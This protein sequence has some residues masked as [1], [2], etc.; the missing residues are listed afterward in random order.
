MDFNPD[1]LEGKSK[2]EIINEELIDHILTSEEEIEDQQHRSGSQTDLNLYLLDNKGFQIGELEEQINRVFE[3]SHI[4]GHAENFFEQH[5][6]G[7]T[8]LDDN[9]EIAHITV[10][11]PEKE[12]EDDSIWIEN[13]GYFWVFTTTPQDW[14]R[15]IENLIKYLPNVERLYLSSE[16]LEILT[17][18]IRDSY[19]SG[20]TAEYHAPY[21]ERRATLQFYGAREEDLDKAKDAFDASPTRI[22]F[23]QTNSPTAAIQGASS[24]A[25]RITFQSVVEGSEDK[26]AETLLNI[27]EGYQEF[28]KQSFEIEHKPT[29]DQLDNGLS[30]EGFTAIELTD[31]EREEDQGELLEELKES[32]LN[33]NQYRYAERTEKTLRVIDTHHDEI[34]DLALEPPDI[35]LYARETTTALSLR[36]IVQD[37]FEDLDSTYSLEKKENPI[38]AQ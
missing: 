13:D 16:M 7:E 27:S 31:P 6:C 4:S 35:I 20:F 29:K 25:G 32:V 19:V 9:N 21:S 18:E 34:F 30:V 28:D 8:V 3:S 15:N 5:P 36:S 26:A 38:A 22:E 23:D 33:S 10:A 24:N 11:T 12:R 37:V 14:R 2:Q 1:V 17:E